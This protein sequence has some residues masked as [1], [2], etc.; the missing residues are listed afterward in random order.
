[1]PLLK[2]SIACAIDDSA[3]ADLAKACSAMLAACTGKPEKYV[4]VVIEQG[5]IM[6]AG[7]A[8]PAAFAGVRGIG[9]LTQEVNRRVTKELCE[10]LKGRFGIAPDRVYATFTEVEAP[11]WGWNK[12]T[13][14]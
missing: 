6:M 2:L 1:M 11:N 7:P 5:S 13:F 4:M 12:T 8:E 9:G 14:G 3:R 10:L